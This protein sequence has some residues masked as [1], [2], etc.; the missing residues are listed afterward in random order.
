[1]IHLPKQPYTW[2]HMDWHLEGSKLSEP[3]LSIND[4]GLVTGPV[5]EFWWLKKQVK[6]Y[7]LTKLRGCHVCCMLL[8]NLRY[9]LLVSDIIWYHWNQCSV[10]KRFKIPKT[11]LA[12]LLPWH[13]WPS[14]LMPPR[15]VQI[16]P[17]A[18]GK[19][20]CGRAHKAFLGPDC[21]IPPRAKLG[22]IFTE[23]HDSNLWN[24]SILFMLGNLALVQRQWIYYMLSWQPGPSFGL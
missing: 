14:N 11:V 6:T 9:Y 18:C 22:W 1:M 12:I 17:R 8:P 4:N 21:Y 13:P 23:I 19:H 16:R 15:C 10:I 3:R 24:Y 7:K 20:K 2:N 5:Q